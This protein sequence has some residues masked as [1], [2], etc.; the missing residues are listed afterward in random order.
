MSTSCASD[1]AGR[2]R[3]ATCYSAKLNFQ[4]VSLTEAARPTRPESRRISTLIG[5]AAHI[6]GIDGAPALTA[7]ALRDPGVADTVITRVSVG[8][9]DFVAEPAIDR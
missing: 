8:A 7:V 3:V 6:V 1:R 5:V 9:A 2:G 4:S